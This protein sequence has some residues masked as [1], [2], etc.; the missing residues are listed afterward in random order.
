[1]SQNKPL[2]IALVVVGLLLVGYLVMVLVSDDAPETVV[3][4]PVA[5]PAP[6]VEPEPEPE[7]VP[8]PP[9]EPAP[10]VAVPEVVPEPAFV[11]PRLDDSDSLVRDGVVS[12]TRD[13]GIN[14]WLGT[15]ELIRKTVVLTDNV[16]NGSIPR[17][18][19]RFLAPETPFVAQQVEEGVYVMDE[20]TYARYNRLT[21]IVASVDA[22]R[23]A[24]FYV[25]LKPLFQQAFDELGYPNARFDDVIFRAI[26]RML[27][28]PVKTEP[29]RL[30]RP[31]VTYEYED[32]KL[33]GLS[34]AQK[35]LLRMGPRNTRA[36]QA[37]LSEIAL[38]LRAILNE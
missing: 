10:E 19:L 3:S 4:E 2:L 24:E 25:L 30:V 35:Q 9:P 5:I 18:Q 12:L 14:S 8:E 13:E 34:D 33:E 1:M 16:S 37:K 11:L 32:P 17:Q 31:V 26:G 6:V 38:E 15:N 22:R 21:D 27:E 7:P 23:A 20:T 28:T 36:I 29:V